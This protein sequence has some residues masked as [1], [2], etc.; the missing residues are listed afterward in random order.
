MKLW[1]LSF[2]FSLS[3]F[4]QD[5]RFITKD[6]VNLSDIPAPPVAQSLKDVLDLEEVYNWQLKRTEADCAKSNYEAEGTTVQSF[7]SVYGPLTDEQALKLAPLQETV[8]LETRYFTRLLKKQFNR[9]RPYDRDPRLKP[10]VEL[11]HSMAYPSGHT[12]MATVLSK[13]FSL[14]YPEHV[15]AFER[16]AHEIALGRVIGGVHHPLDTEAGRIL[17][18]KVFEALKASPEFMAEVEKYKSSK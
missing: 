11:E 15:A 9:P 5:F 13:V 3:L 8:Y 17:G 18:T 7:G 16:R 2:L 6:A 12:T 10:C 4:A 14:I 1:L